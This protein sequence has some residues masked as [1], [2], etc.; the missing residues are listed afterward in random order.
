MF[1][2]T[3]PR[4]TK[5][6]GPKCIIGAFATRVLADEVVESL[7][8]ERRGSSAVTE[9]PVCKSMVDFA[10]AQR[11][12]VIAQLDPKVRELLGV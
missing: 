5:A 8:E 11:D 10:K 1:I 7:S 6:Q 12:A 3:A 9:Y 2:V 4:G